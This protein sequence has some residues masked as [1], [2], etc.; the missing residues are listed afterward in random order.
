MSKAE[1]KT[2][3]R[4]QNRKLYDTS[5]SC[6]ITLDDLAEMI[7]SGDDIVVLDNKTSKD[8]TSNT[9]TQVIFETEKKAKTLIPNHLLQDII[10]IGGGSISEFFQKTQKRV[11]KTVKTGAREIAQV[12]GEI[13]K[14]IEDVTG[15]SHLHHEIDLLEKK[16]SH[17]PAK[18]T[19]YEAE[20]KES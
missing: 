3:K 14:R 1:K 20:G 2:I 6:Y 10:K 15:V 11:Q 17:L 18:L 13:Q 19:K 12:K 4:Y 7:R 8:I 16:V 5:R 9:L